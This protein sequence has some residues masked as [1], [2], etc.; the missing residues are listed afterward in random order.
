MRQVL[1]PATEKQA[2][3]RKEAGSFK[4]GGEGFGRADGGSLTV[5]GSKSEQRYEQN[6]KECGERRKDVSG[7]LEEGW[8][9]GVIHWLSWVC[10]AQPGTIWVQQGGSGG[11]SAN[12]GGKVSAKMEGW[13]ENSVRWILPFIKENVCMCVCVCVN[14]HSRQL[15]KS[16][17]SAPPV[18]YRAL[19]SGSYQSDP[20]DPVLQYQ[21]NTGTSLKP[22]EVLRRQQQHVFTVHVTVTGLWIGW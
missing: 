17:S 21:T 3:R 15:W 22:T 9:S 2:W 18:R 10:S 11:I 1:L 16:H 7:S 14:H 13:R 12:A 8:D 4:G 5:E 19:L 20:F 6:G